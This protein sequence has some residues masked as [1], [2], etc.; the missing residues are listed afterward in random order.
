M[1]LVEIANELAAFSDK[2]KLLMLPWLEVMAILWAINIFNWIIGSKLNYLGIYP[3]NLF[4]L[5]G[6]FFSP[7]L[8]HDFSHL[9]FNSIPLFVLGLVLLVQG[10]DIFIWV[11]LFV[12]IVGGL[13]VWLFG[14]KALHIGASGLISGYFG[15]VLVNAFLAP[16]LISILLSPLVL[17]YF[18]SIFLGIFPQEEG[19]SWES[20]LLG[21]IAGVICAYVPMQLQYL[22]A[23]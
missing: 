20:H 23:I 19:I 2:S 16:S 12:A 22:H 11:T 10:V 5:V 9:L 6:I 8:H 1:S 7:L 15:F 14:R 18:G 13:G 21:F 17:Y 4:G 3:R